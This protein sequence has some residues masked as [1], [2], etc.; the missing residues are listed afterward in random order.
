MFYNLPEV[1]EPFYELCSVVLVKFDIREVHF[2]NGGAWIAHIE[3]HQL[4]FPQVHR[5]Q[6]TG[7]CKLRS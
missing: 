1:T 5:G 6:S 2:Q 4:G 3:E 7:V